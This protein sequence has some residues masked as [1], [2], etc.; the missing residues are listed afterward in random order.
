MTSHRAPLA[1]IAALAIV[2]AYALGRGDGRASTLAETQ[3]RLAQRW[4]AQAVALLAGQD[5]T[6]SS[7]Q[8]ATPAPIDAPSP[9]RCAD[10]PPAVMPEAVR[11]WCAEIDAAA[12]AWA[13]DPRAMALVV[14]Q[15]CPWADA[16]C[17]SPMGA[18]GLAQIMPTTAPEI[19]A[20]TGLPC[21]AGRNGVTLDPATNLKC[22][23]WY[24]AQRLRDAA[25]AWHAGDEAAHVAIA[26]SGYNGG[27]GQGARALAAWRNG[28]HPCEAV[29]LPSETRDYCRAFYDRWQLM[30]ASPSVPLEGTLGIAWRPA[31]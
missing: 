14:I 9:H 2:A 4:G 28:G 30:T 18:Q 19:A 22:G 31:P 5:A 1:I 23:A 29:G 10:V 17:E 16:A 26:A 3:A 25:P 12:D 15:E 24:Y 6:P 27:P 21:T 13:M 8:Q 11:A 7:I 20:A